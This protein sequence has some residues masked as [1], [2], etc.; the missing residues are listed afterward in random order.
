[1]RGATSGT[2]FVCGRATKKKRRAGEE[3]GPVSDAF[4]ISFSSR[5]AFRRRAR[6]Q[7]NVHKKKTNRNGLFA[8]DIQGR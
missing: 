3:K 6:E 2:A 5:F 4:A 1:V 8:S 7:K